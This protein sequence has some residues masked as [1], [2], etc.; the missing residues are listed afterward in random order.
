MKQHGEYGLFETYEAADE[1]YKTLINAGIPS[2]KEQIK[3]C[4]E[5][6][7]ESE[8]IYIKSRSGIYDNVDFNVYYKNILIIEHMDGLELK[9]INKAVQDF[10]DYCKRNNLMIEDSFIFIWRSIIR[11]NAM[12]KLR[13]VVF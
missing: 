10:N 4:K 6:L 7:T 5:D 3:K 2:G 12:Y 8:D 13:A 9:K 1:Y 11:F